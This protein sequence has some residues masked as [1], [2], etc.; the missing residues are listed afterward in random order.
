MA[1]VFTLGLIVRHQA[2]TIT[3]LDQNVNFITKEAKVY[4]VQVGRSD[5]L[6][7]LSI[8]RL[9]LDVKRY[10]GYR[11][12]DACIIA[13]LGLKIKRV[14]SVV[15]SQSETIYQLKTK[16][17]DSIVYRDSLR[18]I[19][20]RCIDINKPWYQ[21]SG[22]IYPDDT[23]EGSMVST[24]SLVYIEHIIPKKFLFIRWGVKERRQEI[25][26]KNP[27][28]KIVSAEFISLKK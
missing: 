25:I 28:T 19:T 24:D 18:P 17:K 12:K 5:S 16:V 21:L 9:N 20:L 10:K 1:A 3:D 15:A 4:R 6:N 2:G 11:E 23:F 22:C 8:Q 26:S 27:D 7:A 14:K 13:D